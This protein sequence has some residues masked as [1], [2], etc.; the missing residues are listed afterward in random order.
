MGEDQ[1]EIFND[2]FT[3]IT[4]TDWYNELEVPAGETV[5]IHRQNLNFTQAELGEKLG[6]KSKQY[7]LDIEKGRRNISLKL[8]RQLG[9]ILEHNYK[10]YL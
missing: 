3:D 4:E 2:N 6:G 1:I 5:V 10:A 8:A 9:D 7:I